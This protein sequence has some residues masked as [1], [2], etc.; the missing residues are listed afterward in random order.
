MK[1]VR[2]TGAFGARTSEIPASSLKTRAKVK[3]ITKT[4]ASR[5]TSP[6]KLKARSKPR[7][8]R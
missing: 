1:P 6:I 8:K 4:I 7:G 2:P 3:A 5:K